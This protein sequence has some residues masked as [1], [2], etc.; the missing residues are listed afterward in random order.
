VSVAHCLPALRA[1]L[2]RVTRTAC[3]APGLI[4]TGRPAALAKS[5][6]NPRRF[7]NGRGWCK[8]SSNAAAQRGGEDRPPA[9]RDLWDDPDCRG[10][11]PA[12]SAASARSTDG[13]AECGRAP[14]LT[15]VEPAEADEALRSRRAL[16]R[17]FSFEEGDRQ[18]E[19][20]CPER[21]QL[22]RVSDDGPIPSLA[23]L[24]V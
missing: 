12:S 2:P 5:P 20:R 13:I 15:C 22:L 9:A 1:L 17:R 4:T 8:G 16:S 21:Q 3:H 19:T 14:Q 23:Q 10:R 6:G 24:D 7:P 11:R 18:R